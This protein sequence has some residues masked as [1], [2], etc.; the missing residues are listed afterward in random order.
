MEW[1]KGNTYKLIGILKQNNAE[2]FL[3]F[4]LRHPEILISKDEENTGNSGSPQIAYPKSWANHFG[5]SYYLQQNSMKLH[6]EQEKIW[7]SQIEGIP[8]DT[9]DMKDV[10]CVPHLKHQIEK[11]TTHLSSQ[12]GQ[13]G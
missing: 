11:I 5:D 2:S 12:E 13:H 10:T 9:E 1:D 8:Y 4:D 6:E 3:L 7:N